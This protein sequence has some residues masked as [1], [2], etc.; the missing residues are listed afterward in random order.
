M[1]TP[2]YSAPLHS[3]VQQTEV[4][5]PTAGLS[6]ILTDMLLS[7]STGGS[8]GTVASTPGGIWTFL[9]GKRMLWRI[10]AVS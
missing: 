9:F 8:D 7:G 6:Y 5:V 3:V 4:I 10:Q 1:R 2:L